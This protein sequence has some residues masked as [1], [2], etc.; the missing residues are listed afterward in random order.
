[1]K[2]TFKLHSLRL[3]TDDKADPVFMPF[4]VPVNA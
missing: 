4:R 1:M 2:D 3:N